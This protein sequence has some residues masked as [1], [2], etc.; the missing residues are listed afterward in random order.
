MGTEGFYRPLTNRKVVVDKSRGWLEYAE[1]L[2]KVFPEARIVSMVRDPEDIV[3]SLETIYQENSGHPETRH[4][5]KTA[6]A[7]RAAWLHPESKPLGLALQRLYER[8]QKPDSR[9]FYVNYD[10]LCDSPVEALR[11]IFEH[12]QLPAFN[13]NPMNVTKATPEN[14]DYYG[15]FGKHSIRSTVRKQDGDKQRTAR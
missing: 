12:L 3:R 15:I 4:L 11:S 14:D 13:I 10:S 1:L 2:W 6:A 7:R 5:P 9:I 8:Q